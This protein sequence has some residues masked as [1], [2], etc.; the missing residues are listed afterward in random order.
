MSRRIHLLFTAISM[1]VLGASS[2]QAQEFKGMTLTV[3]GVNSDL[4]QIYTQTYGAQF[5]KETGAKLVIATGSSN[6]N[7]SKA[8]VA[9]N[10]KPTFQVIALEDLALAQAVKAGAVQKVGVSEFLCARQIKACPL[11]GGRLHSTNE[12]W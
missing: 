3:L 1:A 7:L 5:E 4:N 8:L 6:D 12:S 11:A 10:R 2:A 9:K